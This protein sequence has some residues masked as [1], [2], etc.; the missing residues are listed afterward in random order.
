MA[1]RSAL[2]QEHIRCGSQFTPQQRN[3]KHAQQARVLYRGGWTPEQSEVLKTVWAYW[4]FDGRV[5]D[6][7][8]EVAG[9]S[10]SE[11]CPM[12][13]QGEG[14]HRFQDPIYPPMTDQDREF[15]NAV[16]VGRS[17]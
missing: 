5:C 16:L 14:S 8:G 17:G 9:D 3:N 12:S 13:S 7:C 1:T 15:F 10:G 11:Y 2:A 6:E 4:G